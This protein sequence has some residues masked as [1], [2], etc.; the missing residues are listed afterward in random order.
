MAAT[1]ELHRAERERSDPLKLLALER[2]QQLFALGV[3]R[4]VPDLVQEQ[5]P[6]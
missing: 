2:T 4:H 5:V 1:P 6:P 3:E